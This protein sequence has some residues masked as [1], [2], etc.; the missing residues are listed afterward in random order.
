MATSGTVVFRPEIAEVIVEAYDRCEYTPA[1]LTARDMASARFSL[2]LMFGEWATRGVNYWTLN[3]TSL[4]LTESTASYALPAGTIDILEPVL[5]RSGNDTP[6]VRLA[7]SEY[8]NL[9]TKTT[10]GRPNQYW[11]DRQYTP[12][13]FLWPVPENST[14]TIEYWQLSQL[15]DVLTSAEDA[16]VPYR[17]NEAMCAGLAA[18]LCLKKV[19]DQGKRVELK[20]DSEIAFD[21]AADDE[22]SRAD[23]RIIPTPV[24]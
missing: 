21:L 7:L 10:E 18:K 12:N 3:Q 6:M 23:L 17:W 24:M 1:A 5:R 4:A 11:F 8:Q 16:D 22:R 20:T 13:I 19:R 9:S 2:N 14:D 15:Q